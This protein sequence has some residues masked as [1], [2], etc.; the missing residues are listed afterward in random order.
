V[1]F[2]GCSVVVSLASAVTLGL[3]SVCDSVWFVTASACP[4][5]LISIIS[6]SIIISISQRV[7]MLLGE[8]P[9]SFGSVDC[10]SD[11]EKFVVHVIAD[12]CNVSNGSALGECIVQPMLFP[13]PHHHSSFGL[14]QGHQV[15]AQPGTPC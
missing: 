1:G 4:A 2:P 14:M 7:N 3:P 9:A 13:S 5:L 6:I 10:R 11:E 12:A 15:S 8:Q